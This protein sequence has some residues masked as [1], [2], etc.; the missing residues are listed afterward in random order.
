MI[1]DKMNQA[2]RECAAISRELTE[3]E[4]EY[5]DQISEAQDHGTHEETEGATRRYL[6]TSKLSQRLSTLVSLLSECFTD[7]VSSTYAATKQ[8]KQLRTR[9]AELYPSSESPDTDSEQYATPVQNELEIP[10]QIRAWAKVQGL[11]VPDRGRIAANIIHEYRQAHHSRS[12]SEV[13]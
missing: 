9:H 6:Q 5:F 2:I 10:S 12:S 1:L 7:I 8:K 4:G 3:L 13:T 11:I